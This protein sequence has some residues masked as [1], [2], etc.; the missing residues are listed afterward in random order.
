M[1]KRPSADL[2][3]GCAL[4]LKIILDREGIKSLA[5]PNQFRNSLQDVAASLDAEAAQQREDAAQSASSKLRRFK[6]IQSSPPSGSGPWASL[7]SA[8]P[9]RPQPGGQFY[10]GVSANNSLRL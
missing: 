1:P 5:P 6:I 3:G 4:N 2:V 9:H 7:D 10:E 8:A